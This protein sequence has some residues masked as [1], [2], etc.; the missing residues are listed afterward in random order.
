MTQTLSLDHFVVSA[1]DLDEGVAHVEQV[2][3]VTLAPGGKHPDMGT[4]NRLLSFGDCYFEVIAP[5][6]DAAPPDQPRWFDLDNFAG[7]PRLT[8]WVVQGQDLAAV[9]GDAPDAFGA[10]TTLSRGDL[11]W[12]ILMAA[13]GKLP[14]GGGFPGL[15]GWGDTPH[16]TTRLPDVGCRLRRWEVQHP[17]AE[18]LREAL[19]RFGG[20]L[21][22]HIHQGPELAFRAEIETPNG[23]RELL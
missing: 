17:Q 11:T 22:A 7:P 9:S 5:D 18:A 3:G 15:I 14:F 10:L 19:D 20:G 23:V 21:S 6:P 16:P 2:L 4:H 13:D 12:E 1:L 8:N